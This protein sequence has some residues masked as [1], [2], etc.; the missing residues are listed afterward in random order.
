MAISMTSLSLCEHL[1]I[2]ISTF[3]YE[4]DPSSRRDI[5]MFPNLICSHCFSAKNLKIK[6]KYEQNRLR[7]FW[8]LKFYS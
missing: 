6:L 7:C 1:K 5:L 3:F 2:L 4:F 8:R